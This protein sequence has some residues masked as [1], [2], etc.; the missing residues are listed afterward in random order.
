[1]RISDRMIQNTFLNGI[2][3]NKNRLQEIQN[4]IASQSKIN[5]PSDSPLGAARIMRLD[6]QIN[7]VN[8]YKSNIDNSLTYMN[9]S[10]N[11]MQGIQSQVQKTLVDLTSA[12]NAT[13]SDNLK[14]F[15]DKIG[16]ELDTI[17][18]YANINFSGKY[19]FSGANTNI[20]P[21]SYDSSGNF[22][23]VN[24]SNIGGIQ[25]V[26]INSNSQQ[27]INITGKE[28]FMPV[29]SITG[30]VDSTTNT[31]QAQSTS[32][33]YDALGNAYNMDITYTKTTADKFDLTYSIKDNAGTIVQTGN[34]TIEFDA[35]TKEAKSVG[36]QLKTD[37][38]IAV[39]NNKINFIV[40][41]SALKESTS[42][43]NIS[44]ALSQKS[45]IFNTL[46]SIKE[47][48]NNGIMPSGN[49][50]ALV[51]SFNTHIL[52]KISEVGDTQNKLT[53]AGNLLD[54]QKLE[55]QKLLS[56]EKDVD[57]AKAVVEL[58]NEQYNLNMSYKIAA[59]ILPKSLLDYL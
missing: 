38:K 12:N 20:K 52:N 23:H 55:L 49:E 44:T 51:K 46:L 21:F 16:N 7:N 39:P 27:K 43:L 54:N 25:N 26:K 11:A 14:L 35:S 8:L 15:A 5:K 53:Y 56:K 17:L 48:L 29:L 41:L 22:I 45:D 50:I 36:G 30:N 33:V 19:L 28:L 37:L 9:S 2:N 34:S 4:E 24:S 1:M 32:T 3:F 13:Q 58:Q 6:Q 18:D 59:M 40:D 47:K 10:V 31:P 42:T 57:I